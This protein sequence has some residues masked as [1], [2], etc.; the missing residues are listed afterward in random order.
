[1][2]DSEDAVETMDNLLLF[3]LGSPN[4]QMAGGETS[5]VSGRLSFSDEFALTGSELMNRDLKSSRP[6]LMI[7]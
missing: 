5:P 6:D 3:D 2:V 7:Y 4:Q 1:M